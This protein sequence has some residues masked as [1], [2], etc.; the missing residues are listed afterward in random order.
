MVRDTDRN[1][2]VFDFVSRFAEA[3]EL[4]WAL[5]Q[6]RPQLLLIQIRAKAGEKLA[7]TRYR[8]ATRRG[9]GHREIRQILFGTGRQDIEHSGEIQYLENWIGEINSSPPADQARKA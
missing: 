5:Q 6:F 9:T 4:A 1:L 7:K 8:D 3:E 2:P